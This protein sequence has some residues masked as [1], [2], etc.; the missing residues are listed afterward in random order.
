M[1][2]FFLLL[3][4]IFFPFA[5]LWAQEGKGKIVHEGEVLTGALQTKAYF[6]LLKGK[7]VGVVANHASRLKE[8]HLVD[9]LV[10][11]GIQV[12]KIFFPE[13]GFRGNEDAGQNLK[14]YQ[15]PQTGITCISLY[16]KDKKPSAQDMAS[17]D[18]VLFDLQDVG[19]R[20]YTYI[21]T[22]HFVM[23]ACAENKKPLIVLDR[24]NP[25]G[26]YIDGP[27]LQTQAKSFVG[28]HP[29][30]VVYG[31]TIGEYAQ[32][33]LGENWLSG[34]KKCSL[35][36]IPLK[37]YDRNDFYQ[38]PVRPSPNLPNMASVYLYPS[39]CFFEGTIVSVGRGT[40]KPFQQFG[41][42]GMKSNGYTFKPVSTPGASLD[43]PYKGEECSGFDVSFYGD[44]YM[45]Y[46]RKLYLFW[47]LETY[48]NS[49]LK[50][51]FFNPYFRNLAGNDVLKEQIM[52][53]KS[54]EEIRKTWA[55]DLQ[56]FK[57]VRKK[58]LIYPD[59]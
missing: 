39:L 42:P 57:E 12:R 54:E 52:S 37:N 40:P 36:V 16:G 27:V 31:M 46:S 55:S 35:K 1:L 59:F 45:K 22:L 18:I 6:P 29:V 26:H 10:A 49:G 13:H 41:Y 9:T 48:K 21:S 20:F 30:P 38:L 34:G 4:T 25:N 56:K 19:V 51:K 50:E 28:L 44:M 53:G 33:I 15:D 5:F 24:P 47:L 58:Y 2:R 8:T 17:L 11:S 3:C 43:P 14:S 32:M 23:E 7:R